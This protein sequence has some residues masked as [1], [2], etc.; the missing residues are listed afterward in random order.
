[1]ELVLVNWSIDPAISFGFI[2]KASYGGFCLA[3]YIL[4]SVY[5]VP[6]SRHAT[7]STV[8]LSHVLTTIPLGIWIYITTRKRNEGNIWCIDS[9]GDIPSNFKVQRKAVMEHGGR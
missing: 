8:L 6:C 3:S 9:D 7:T 2:R 4:R 5:S 1:M